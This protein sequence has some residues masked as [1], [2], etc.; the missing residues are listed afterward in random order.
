MAFTPAQARFRFYN[1]DGSESAST[2]AAAQDTNIT[3][4]VSSGNARLQLRIGVQE[5]GGADG[6]PRR[7]QLQYEKNDSGVWNNVSTGSSNVKAFDSANL[8]DGG[9][10]TSR[11]SGGTGSFVAGEVAETGITGLAALTASNKTEHLY[12]VEFIAA[13]VADGDTFDFRVLFNSSVLSGGYSVTPRATVSASTYTLTSDSGSYALTGTD[14]TLK[15]GLRLEADSGNY[16]LT[17]TSATL[18]EGK[19]ISADAGSYALTGSDATLTTSRTMVAASGSYAITGS[20]SVLSR[21][22]E[23]ES[24]LY[25]ITG[26][27]AKFHHRGPYK[28]WT[29]P[30]EHS[31]HTT[32]QSRRR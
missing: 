5:T 24:G 29:P 16:S 26:G 2:A 1:D 15:L 13:D 18:F 14:V 7:W 8:T 28:F 27:R 17:G 4:D 19:G 30:I 10:T 20:S 12:T 9:S 6:P 23:V 31:A 25:R 32:R 11:L 3:A 22:F 21:T